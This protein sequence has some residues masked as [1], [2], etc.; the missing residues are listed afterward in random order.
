MVFPLS[1][2]DKNKANWLFVDLC[3]RKFLPIYIALVMA[4]VY[5]VNRVTFGIY[6]V[7]IMR[8]PLRS[9]GSL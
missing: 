3:F 5:A 1:C 8:N 6:F 4:D 7:A 2:F 9:K